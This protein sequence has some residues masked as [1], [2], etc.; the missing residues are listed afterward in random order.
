MDNPDGTGAQTEGGGTGGGLMSGAAGALLPLALGAAS[1]M[2]PK[3]GAQMLQSLVP[4]LNLQMQEQAF[5]AIE[6]ERKLTREQQKAK[7]ERDRA[8]S[9]AAGKYYGFPEDI[10]GAVPAT[11]LVAMGGQQQ[12]L[13][14]QQNKE[15]RAEAERKALGQFFTQ[16]YPETFQPPLP[17]P[18]VELP[19]VAAEAEQG[20]TA[21]PRLPQT[22]TEQRMVTQDQLNALRQRQM[23]AIGTGLQIPTDVLAA[24]KDQ[25]TAFKER[26]TELKPTPLPVEAKVVTEL[27]RSIPPGT[28]ADRVVAEMRA[29]DPVATELVRQAAI[30]VERQDR[31][32]LTEAAIV[33]QSIGIDPTKALSK[34]DAIRLN[35]RLQALK[36]EQVAAG[37]ALMPPPTEAIR[38]ID[39]AFLVKRAIN[40]IKTVLRDSPSPVLGPITGTWAMWVSQPYVGT[41]PYENALHA[42]LNT[43]R[44][45][46]ISLISGQQTSKQEIE[47]AISRMSGRLPVAQIPQGPF[48]ARLLALDSKL[49]SRLQTYNQAYSNT[50]LGSIQKRIELEKDKQLIDITALQ[51]PRPIGRPQ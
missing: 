25:E 50:T 42:S 23:T 47:R 33:A 46:D 26:L 17:T 31:P 1:F 51:R 44:D 48:M 49:D 14:L 32:P 16:P 12:Q 5:G 38:H 27:M 15:R 39:D 24:I 37:R 10:A 3:A 21:A 4:M 28:T 2:N 7:D 35:L 29:G 9:V 11:N 6:R 13:T 8:A 36:M 41:D 43:L 45:T 30:A 22:S 40:T 20:E 34:P 18:R 19:D